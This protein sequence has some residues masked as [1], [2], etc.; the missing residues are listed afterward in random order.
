MSDVPDV[1]VRPETPGDRDASLHVIRR[2]FGETDPD[3]ATKVAALLAAMHAEADTLAYTGL[4]A[5]VS[6]TVVGH[7]GLTRGWV[8]A[9][10]A[11]VEIRVLSPL[12]VLP[13]HQGD[14]VGAA[15]LDAAA[16]QAEAVGAPVLLLEGDPGYYGRHGYVAAGTVGLVRPSDRI[17][18]AACQVRLLPGHRPSLTGRLV[19]P[20]VFWRFDAVGLRGEMLARVETALSDEG[21]A[22]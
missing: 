18:V 22:G 1:T 13:E 4:V 3:E 5:V 10:H 16:V 15:L 12:A 8:D 20:D 17:P 7:A 14:G 19:Y 11:L 9:S 2:A 6:G 21:G